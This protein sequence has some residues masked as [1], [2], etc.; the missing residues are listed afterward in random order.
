MD[1]GVSATQ[2]RY[3]YTDEQPIRADTAIKVLAR[4]QKNQAVILGKL[5]SC[6]FSMGIT[7]HLSMV[8]QWL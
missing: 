4:N 5:V 2:G 8:A 7:K 1:V 3:Y 6:V